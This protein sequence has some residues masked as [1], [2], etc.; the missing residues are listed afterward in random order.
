M[1]SKQFT[2]IGPVEDPFSFFGFDFGGG[3]GTN[4][5]Q[6]LIDYLNEDDSNT[7]HIILSTNGGDAFIAT[8]MVD[9]L[10]GY[11]ERITMEIN[12]LSASAGSLLAFAV[13]NELYVRDASMIMIHGPSTF[14]FGTLQ[15]HRN[16]V[17][18]LEKVSDVLRNIY[19]TNSE[20][21]NTQIQDALDNE[22]WLTP[23]E[24]IKYNI[25]TKILKPNKRVKSIVEQASNDCEGDTCSMLQNFPLQKIAAVLNTRMETN[26]PD[27]VVVDNKSSNGVNANTTIEYNVDPTPDL[28]NNNNDDDNTQETITPSEAA[29]SQENAQLRILVETQKE[30]IAD[31]RSRVNREGKINQQVRN[32]ETI[33]EAIRTGRIMPSERAKWEDRLEKGGELL[34]KSLIERP[35]SDYFIENGVAFD[36]NSLEAV[37]IEI[38]KDLEAQGYSP[39]DIVKVYNE[40]KSRGGIN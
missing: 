10:S 39:E 6:E 9:M 16:T 40:E 35:P 17:Q 32:K 38:R 26:L 22:L 3:I 7:A 23:Q 25:A 1:P 34:R 4:T 8:R 29:L 36:E 21:T 20:L 28:D 24:M 30:E 11:Q 37:P 12:G 14:T 19:R 27:E 5:A 31:L 2:W 15:E 13:P 33:I 18:R